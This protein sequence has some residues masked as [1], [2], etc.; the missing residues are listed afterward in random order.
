M[1]HVDCGSLCSTVVACMSAVV[2]CM[3]AVVACMSAVVAVEVTIR[4]IGNREAMHGQ[5]LIGWGGNRV[6]SHPPMK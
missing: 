3:S 2:A 4:G 1:Q 5:G 6:A